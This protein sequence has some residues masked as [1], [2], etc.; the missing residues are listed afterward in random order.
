MPMID[1][2]HIIKI[3]DFDTQELIYFPTHQIFQ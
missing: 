1:F 3:P 2:V